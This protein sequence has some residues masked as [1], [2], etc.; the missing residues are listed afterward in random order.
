[1][2]RRKLIYSFLGILLI[3]SFILA[4]IIFH[5][6]NRELKVAIFDVGQGDA[7]LIEQGNNQILID[8]GPSG[9]KVLEKMGLYMPF[10]D[11]KIEIIIATHPDQDHIAGLIEVMKNYEIGK[12][13][14]NGM[15]AES[16]VYKRFKEIIRQKNISEME[17]KREMNIK[18]S[19]GAELKILW[20]RE[21][22]NLKDSNGASIVARLAYGESSF[23]FTGDLPSDQE[24][25]LA[26]QESNLNSQVLKVAHHG[27][28]YSTGAEFLDKI[29]PEKAVIS[30]GKNS[31][32]HPSQEV[33]DRLDKKG[34]KILRT[35]KIGDIVY[36][37]ENNG[38]RC[39]LNID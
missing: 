15:S 33:L 1:M 28:K 13:M 24:M 23:L 27:S 31:Y 16:Q 18:L 35:D 6:Q 34:I 7:I 11:R 32:G 10:W 29:N 21:G 38:N 8:G 17:G 4:G 19:G 26:S 39:E 37:C 22:E 12:I 9:Q 30:V 36:N 5:S 14:D 2:P 20:P 3:V 25:V